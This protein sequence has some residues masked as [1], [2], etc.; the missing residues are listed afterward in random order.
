VEPILFEAAFGMSPRQS[1]KNL[2]KELGEGIE[3]PVEIPVEG[4]NILRI[5]GKIDRVDR[6]GKNLY[7]IIDYKTGSYSNYE[8]L[9]CFG[10]GQ[11]LQHVLYSVAAEC[12]LK[13]LKLDDAPKVVKSGYYFPTHRGEGRE[14]LIEREKWSEYTGLLQVLMNILKQGFFLISPD[15]F[16]DYCEFSPI[17]GTKAKDHAKEKKH[18]QAEE[19]AV[20]NKLKEYE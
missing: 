3:E 11:T 5:R 10:H 20:F 17:C 4:K 1:I 19:Y 14:I 8:D 18:N 12:I 6:I 7:R 9:I 16:C 2:T 13:K 15:A